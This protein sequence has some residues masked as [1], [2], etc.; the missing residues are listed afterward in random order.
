MNKT[1]KSDM[2]KAVI[3]MGVSG[4]GKTTIGLKLAERLGWKFIESDHFH[5][6]ENIQK[7][8]SGIPLTD[9]DRELWLECLHAVLVDRS[10][11]DQSVIMT[12]SALKERYRQ[13]L[14]FGL[15][16]IC[17]VYLKGDYDLIWQRMQAREHFMKPEMLKSQFEALEEP[18]DAIIIDISKSP[19]QMIE[20][21]LVQIQG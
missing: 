14:K 3:V 18:I 2:F 11:D 17:F 1:S 10:R 13:I 21:I 6:R 20:E 7:M 15:S 9:A 19:D 12:C 4:S 5:S 16:G 8:A